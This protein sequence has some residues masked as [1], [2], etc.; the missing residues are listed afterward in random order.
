MS[1][2]SKKWGTFLQLF[3]LVLMH[4][5]LLVMFVAQVPTSLSI[6]VPRMCVFYRNFYCIFSCYLTPNYPGLRWLNSCVNLTGVVQGPNSVGVFFPLTWGQ[7]QIQFPNR[8]VFYFLG[9]PVI[10]CVIHHRQNPLESTY[11]ISISV[12]NISIMYE[13]TYLHTWN[14]NAYTFV[15]VEHLMITIQIKTCRMTKLYC[16]FN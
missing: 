12:S 11:F 14:T 2:N 10:L 16:K 4:L 9:N 13:Y 1:T 3:S 7:K 8:R 6:L 15:F 5:V